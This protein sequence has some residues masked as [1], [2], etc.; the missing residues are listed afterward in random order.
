MRKGAENSHCR[1]ESVSDLFFVEDCP[2]LCHLDDLVS[3]YK[4]EDDEN[5][6]RSKSSAGMIDF[7]VPSDSKVS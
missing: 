4:Q 7:W 3:E 6:E 5:D 1:L 2:L